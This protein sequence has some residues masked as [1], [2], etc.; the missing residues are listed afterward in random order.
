MASYERHKRYLPKVIDADPN[1]RI[2][3]LEYEEGIPV[4]SIQEEGHL[5]GL[6]KYD[7]EDILTEYESWVR[8]T[9]PRGQ[10]HTGLAFWEENTLYSFKDRTFRLIDPH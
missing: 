10:G 9:Y 2:L 3:I 1:N 6:S 4:I 8:Q 5:Y 7:I